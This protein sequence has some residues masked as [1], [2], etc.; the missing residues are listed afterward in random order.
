MGETPSRSAMRRARS[1]ISRV[2]PPPPFPWPKGINDH[3]LQP[4]SLKLLSAKCSSGA[5][6]S[7]LYV[8]TGGKCVS[9][10]VPSR[11]CHQKVEWG[12]RFCLFQL[13]FWVTNRV[14]PPWRK[15]CGSVAGY[16]NT[17]GIQTSELRVPNLD[18]K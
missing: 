15:I 10:R 2:G 12:N 7:A 9:T 14:Q 13:N 18:S 3:E 6:I 1:N 5:V 4:C 8:S 11:P 16:P 17:S